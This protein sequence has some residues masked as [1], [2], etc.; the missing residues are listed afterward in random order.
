MPILAG[1]PALSRGRFWFINYQLNN[2]VM[3]LQNA[4]LST[5]EDKI[6]AQAQEAEAKVEKEEK[7]DLK[8]SVIIKKKS[9]KN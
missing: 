9:K 7:K 6:E 4:R 8:R 2:N 5:L 3:S 1:E